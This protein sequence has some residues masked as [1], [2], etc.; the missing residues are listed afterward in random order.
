MRIRWW[1]VPNRS[2]TSVEYS[3][4]SPLSPPADSKPIENVASPV[5]PASA[6]RPTTRLESMPPDSSTPTGTSATI[7]RSTASRSRSSSASS[8]S[9]DV[10][11]AR[12]GSRVNSGSQYTRSVVAPSGSIVRTV[13]G[14]SLPMPARMVRGAGTT[15][16]NVM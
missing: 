2:A 16:W 10:Q 11:S 8:Q 3:N 1:S 4:S 15:E 9:R 12:S 13:A 6:S 5:C 14:G 7:R